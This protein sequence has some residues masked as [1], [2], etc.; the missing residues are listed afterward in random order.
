M[1]APN[2]LCNDLTVNCRNVENEYLILM[3]SNCQFVKQTT[4]AF[5]TGG[6]KLSE[7]TVNG[8]AQMQLYHHQL[9]YVFGRRC[10]IHQ[11]HLAS[12]E[13]IRIFQLNFTGEAWSRILA[14][15]CA[16]GFLNFNH[17]SVASMR[18]AIDGLTL[19]NPGRLFLIPS[20][21][22]SGHTF[23]LP[24]PANFILPPD[25]VAVPPPADFILPP[26]YV[27]VLPPACLRFLNLASLQS[28]EVDGDSPWSVICYMSGSL[29]RC[30]TRASRSEPSSQ[31]Q[32]ISKGWAA[33]IAKRYPP[34]IDDFDKAE[35]LRDYLACCQL[36]VIFMPAGVDVLELKNAARDAVSYY[37]DESGRKSIEESRL[38]FI[39]HR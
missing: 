12:S 29:G 8:H 17:L 22:G 9:M 6:W 1:A 30:L 15:L 11:D 3:H 10:R 31:I 34:S 21:W 23:D 4:P 24:P 20:D 18:S 28:L 27:A 26:D 5:G 35:N 16:S 7:H 25:Y 32:L 33:G 13:A 19:K 14:E 37:M 2:E 36:P 39:G 38:K